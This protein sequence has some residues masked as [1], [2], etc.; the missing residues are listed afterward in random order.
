MHNQNDRGKAVAIFTKEP[1][2]EEQIQTKML[3]PKVVGI[4]S[5]ISVAALVGGCAKQELI[6]EGQRVNLRTP[7][8][9]AEQPAAAPENQ[10]VKISLGKTVANAS[11]THRNGSAE[12]QIK[13]PA[14][15]ANLTEIWAAKIGA[16]ES[17]KY[18]ITAD[19]VVSNGRVF[20]LDS[21]ANVMAHSTSGEALWVHDLTPA[22]DRQGD[23]SGGGLAVEGGTVFA[24]TGYG[25]L[26]AIDA[27][28]GNELWV[29]KL[30][31][32]ATGAPTVRDGIV[33]VSARDSSGWA[34]DAKSG[35]VKWQLPAT[36]TP[37]VVSGGA[38]PVVTDKFAIFPFGS[39]ELVAAFRKG[40]IRIWASQIS[41]KRRGRA[42]ASISDITGDPVVSGNTVYVASQS[43][44]L[45]AIDIGSGERIWTAKEGSYSPV[46][47]VGGSVFLVSD[48]AELVRLDA[49]NG[50]RIWGTKLPYYTKVKPKRRQA[51]F[52]H[53]G[54]V[55]AGGR[56]IV[57]SSDG[58]IR[59]YN[60]MDGSLIST[61]EI[62]GGAA[63]NPVVAGGV[64]Y[65]VSKKGQL[66]AYR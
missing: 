60:P 18:R 54:P 45:A 33:Y 47:A 31:A 43:G 61:V 46:W 35:R 7:L 11:W 34:I 52:S 41:G 16:G 57:S 26:I 12:H 19:P 30:E 10:S 22:S 40:G 25:A 50:A 55:L 32:S 17:R 48:Q 62:K 23:A 3:L 28:T 8:E 64:L 59:S 2:S 36:P 63:T 13:H 66:H 42:Y 21:H 38:G 20:T 56:L 51:V 24:T 39:G 53:F 14:L 27:A 5:I 44:R 37:S 15:G 9:G 65:V 49:Q 4:V 1:M 29:Q 58:F 6:L